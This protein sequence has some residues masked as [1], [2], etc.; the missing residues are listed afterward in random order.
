VRYGHRKTR[1]HGDRRYRQCGPCVSPDGAC[2][3]QVRCGGHDTDGSP[4][5]SLTTLGAVF[6]RR[7]GTGRVITTVPFEIDASNKLMYKTVKFDG[8]AE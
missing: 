1:L 3:L 4:G 2:E 7:K 5:S 8:Q 6:G